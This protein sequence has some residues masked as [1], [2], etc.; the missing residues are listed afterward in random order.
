MSLGTQ[1]GPYTTPNAPAGGPPIKNW[2][3]ESILSTLCCCV[4]IGVIGIIFAAQVNS[5]LAQGDR[6]G[7]EEAAKKAKMFTLIAVGLGLVGIVIS[8]ILN[9]A[10]AAA[11]AQ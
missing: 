10:A 6:V 9:I 5:K 8:I 11:Q 3:V 2:L 7:A 4:P 1:P